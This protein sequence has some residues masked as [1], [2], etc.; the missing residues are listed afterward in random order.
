MKNLFII[1]IL[2]LILFPA[3]QTTAQVRGDYKY[4]SVI[5]GDTLSNIIDLNGNNLLSIGVND[6]TA[7]TKLNIWHSNYAD[8]TF[9]QVYYDGALLEIIFT[10]GA[11][12]IMKPWET[13]SLYRYIKLDFQ[14]IQTDTIIGNIGYGKF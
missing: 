11:S 7:G 6:S 3:I 4:Y 9:K 1:L 14:T 13:T 12:I 2:F 10:P 5:E 8:S